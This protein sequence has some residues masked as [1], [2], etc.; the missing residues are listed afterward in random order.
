MA[1][2]KAWSRVLQEKGKYFKWP[3]WEIEREVTWPGGL[4]SVLLYYYV[5]APGPA[6]RPTYRVQESFLSSVS[7]WQDEMQ[8]REITQRVYKTSSLGHLG[9]SVG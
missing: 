6:T 7:P 1:T 5:T 9:G 4:P 8:E 3:V 2:R